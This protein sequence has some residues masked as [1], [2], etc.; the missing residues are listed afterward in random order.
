MIPVITVT[1][2]MMGSIMSSIM[3]SIK[4]STKT[5]IKSRDS[6]GNN[7]NRQHRASG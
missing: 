3:S 6:N 7:G 1:R 5:N 2:S 4:T